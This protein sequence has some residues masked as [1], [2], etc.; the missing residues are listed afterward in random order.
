MAVDVQRQNA[1]ILDGRQVAGASFV[2]LDGCVQS[3]AGYT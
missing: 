2:D 3:V 1:G